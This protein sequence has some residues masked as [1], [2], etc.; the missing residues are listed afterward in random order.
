MYC[1]VYYYYLSFTYI[2]VSLMVNVGRYI[3]EGSLIANFRQYG[4]LKKQM[5]QAVK[6]K[7][8]RCTSAKVRRKKIHPRQMLQKSRNA[9][10]FQ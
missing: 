5:R 7:V 2:L 6:S 8:K 4:E 3:I 10:F 9:V 1:M